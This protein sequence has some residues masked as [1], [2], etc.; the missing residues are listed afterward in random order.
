MPPPGRFVS[1]DGR[2]VL[3]VSDANNLVPGDTNGTWDIFVRD[4]LTN[5]TER[6]SVSS[7]GGQSNGISGVYG[8]AISRDGN[9]VA[10]ES[11]ANNLVPGDTNGAREVFVHDRTTGV[12]ERV[13]V[14]ASGNQGNGQSFYPSL[15]ADGRFV[16]FTSNSSNLVPGD[17]NGKWDTFVR[18][19]W[20]GSVERISVSSVGLQ[21]SDDSY[22][23]EVSADGRFVVFESLASNLVP[24]DTNLAWDVL[25]RDR[26]TGT[27]ERVSISTAG[28]EPNHNS[29]QAAV[30]DD[31]RYVVFESLA[32]NL[33][34]GDTNMTDDVFVHDRQSGVTAR[35][36]IATD[37]TESESW[38]GAPSITADGR[39]VLFASGGSHLVSGD[40]NASIDA[41]T[42]DSR[43]GV[44]ERVSVDSH[45][46]QTAGPVGA[47]T[48]SS[49]GRFVVFEDWADDLVSGDTNGF[50]DIFFHDRFASGF[51]S[52][53]GPGANN[54]IAC[55]C[56]NPPSGPGR[57]CDNSSSTG[58]AALSASGIAY[59][60]LDSL[61]FSTSGE[62]PSA[63]SILLQGDTLIPS[64]SSFGQGVRCVGGMLKRLYVK[65]AVNG[66]ITAPDLGAGDPTV[67]LRSAQLGA[68]IQA[69]ETRLFLVYYRDA[70]VLGGC[71]AAN[72]FN[73]TQTGVVTYWP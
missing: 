6:V 62:K 41:F 8:A 29:G 30:S 71:P 16:A 63:T 65:T 3:F 25:L 53:C 42:H 11:V 20:T 10:F 19:R 70:T 14:D 18:D 66:S 61:A 72:T 47:G 33:A 59:L 32:S 26:L 45:G 15:S 24:G 40:T 51:T 44:T 54:V 35:V 27:T 68:P 43:S 4:R 37:G 50:I 13:A 5:T 17:T 38:S 64:G 22:K 57:G 49:D 7:S 28:G 36:S 2:F 60:S 1:S 73:S 31:G 48:I 21:G 46:L 12:T 52:L 39:I 9:V 67:S 58:G 69:G 55:P 23:G 34:P 56:N